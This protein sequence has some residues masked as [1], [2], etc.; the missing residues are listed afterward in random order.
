MRSSNFLE[1]GIPEFCF[2]Q[3]LFYYPVHGS[4]LTVHWFY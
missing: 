2:Y 4:L 1:K 3:R